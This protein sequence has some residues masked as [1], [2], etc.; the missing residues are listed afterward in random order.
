MLIKRFYLPALLVLAVL[1]LAGCNFTLAA[2]ITPPPDYTPPPPGQPAQPVAV[3]TAFPLLPPNPQDGAA[4]Y[5]VK[6]LPCHGETGKGDGPQSANLPARPA[7]IGTAALAR[8]SRPADWFS[9]VTEGRLDRFMPG[10]SGSLDDRQRWDVIAYVYT[11]SSTPE[12][13]AA[14]KTL[15]NEQCAACHGE[16]GKGDGSKAQ[17]ANLV[18]WVKQERLAQL[19]ETDMDAIILNGKGDMTAYPNLTAD[20]LASLTAYIRNLTFSDSA[21]Q[22]ASAT[23]PSPEVT[24]TPDTL[25]PAAET[26]AASTPA[27]TPEAKVT[28]RGKISGQNG[29]KVPSGLE[30]SLVSFEGMNQV[31]EIKTKSADDGSYSF[32]VE[33]KS[34]LTYMVRV[35]YN[36]IVYSSDILHGTD[37]KGSEAQLP[38]TIYETSV[39]TTS[40][41][42][43]RLHIFFDFSKPATVQVAELFIISNTGSKVVVAAGQDKPPLT[44]Q[45]PKDAANLQFE[46]GS[47]GDRF[48]QP[49]DGFG[50]LQAIAP[51][52]SQHQVL[53]SYELPYDSKL[54]LKIPVPRAV[55]ATVVMMPQGGVKLQSPQLQASGSQDVQ[56]LTY[57]LYTG[58]GLVAGSGLSIELS[59]KVGAAGDASSTDNTTGLLIGLGVFGLVLA[60]AGFW[61]FQKRSQVRVERIPEEEAEASP[62]GED[63]LVDQILALDDLYQAGKLP[64]E[65]YR[66]RRAELKDRLRAVMGG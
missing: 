5:A 42:I 27:G 13:V 19:S 1:V 57:E 14:G 18:D 4:I 41:S 51:G 15:Y 43:D 54:S 65:A 8:K 49:A 28:L 21:A 20:Q 45:L 55:N 26:P 46:G 10:F 47:L 48:V 16:S 23:T 3:S 12:E 17:G 60:A 9:V 25:T 64:E 61:L 38:V 33:N 59:G 31:A 34:T 35:T 66:S 37:I 22:Q 50:D 39:D 11:L 7:E 56:G 58:S 52:Q 6:C 40:L 53:F 32:E 24:G 63:A 62:D 30:V 36:D 2:D 29:L 44:F